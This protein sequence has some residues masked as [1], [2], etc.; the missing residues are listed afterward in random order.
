MAAINIHDQCIALI[1]FVFAS[2]NKEESY[3]VYIR[4]DTVFMSRI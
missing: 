4:P 2:E 1:T 3:F